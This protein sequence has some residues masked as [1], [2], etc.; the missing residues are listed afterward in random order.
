M[1]NFIPT[2]WEL[3]KGG[4]IIKIDSGRGT[5]TSATARN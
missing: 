5:F 4:K 1:K 2:S 3:R